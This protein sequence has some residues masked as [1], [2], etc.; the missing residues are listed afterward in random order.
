MKGGTNGAGYK[1]VCQY[2]KPKSI[3]RLVASRFL[4]QP[5]SDKC[6]ID[7]IDR[8][9]SNNHASNLRWCSSSDNNL[10]KE[11]KLSNTGEKHIYYVIERGCNPWWVQIRR[12]NAVIFQKYFPTKE[13]A[14]TARDNFINSM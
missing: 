7:H 3:H 8:D 2:G 13:E 1:R 10:N 6:E 5:T 12:N 9:K 11:H 4:P 14:I